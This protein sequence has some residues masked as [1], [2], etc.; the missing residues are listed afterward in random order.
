MSAGQREST[1]EPAGRSASASRPRRGRLRRL[2]LTLVALAFAFWLVRGISPSKP[3]TLEPGTNVVAV[4]KG[5]SA[6]VYGREFSITLIDDRREAVRILANWFLPL[7]PW[8]SPSRSEARSVVFR[9][10]DS[11]PLCR[12]YDVALGEAV[13]FPVAGDAPLEAATIRFTGVFGKRAR[14]EIRDAFPV[15]D[16]DLRLELGESLAVRGTDLT[17]ALVKVSRSLFLGPSPEEPTSAAQREPLEVTYTVRRTGSASQ[18]FVQQSGATQRFGA[19]TIEVREVLP[20]Q[21]RFRVQAA[22]TDERP[23]GSD[24]T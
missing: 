2:L 5:A 13:V 9:A 14:F 1:T 22:A 3:P 16:P 10:E 12:Q 4:L 21:V 20:T 24:C 17:I 15:Y 6:A 23:R 18:S 7:S 11:R 19:L 8:R